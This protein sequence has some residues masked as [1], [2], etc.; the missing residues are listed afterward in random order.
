MGGY[1]EVHGDLRSRLITPISCMITPVFPFPYF[2][3]P[4]DPP[5]IYWGFVGDYDLG[6]RTV[7]APGVGASGGL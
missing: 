4:H 5:S 6:V 1:L 7:D 3:S 2:L